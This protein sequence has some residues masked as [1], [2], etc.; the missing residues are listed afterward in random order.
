LHDDEDVAVRFAD[1]VDRADIGMVERGSSLAS[2]ISRS[3][4]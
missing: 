1:F 4:A 2:L 3:L